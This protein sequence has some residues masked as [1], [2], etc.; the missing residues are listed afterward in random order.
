MSAV[1][2]R[3]NIHR[4]SVDLR[5]PFSDYGFDSLGATRLIADLG[6][7]LGR[8]LPATLAWEHPNI[9][10]LAQW[11]SGSFAAGERVPDGRRTEADEP[12]AVVGLACRFP[13]GRNAAEFWD[14][15]CSG[16]DA[17]S[18]VPPDRWDAAAWHDPSGSTPGKIVTRLGGFLESVDRFDSGFFGISPREAAFMDPQQRLM[19]ELSWEALEDG[20]IP[21]LSLRDS[22]TGVFFGVVW[23]DYAE[24]QAIEAV[25]P[26]QHTAAGHSASIVA[27][28]VSYV[29]GLRGPSLA[30]DTACSS[31]LVAVHQA[32]QSLRGGECN[33][34]LAGGVML[35]L[36]PRTSGAVSAF[37]GLSPDGRCK[38][39][40]ASANGYV[41]G[42]G[43][44]VVVLKRL[45]DALAGG[46]PIYCVI[47]GSA[48]NN[49]GAT[50]G[51]T[52]PSL[53]A[54][55]AVLA[56]ACAS[57]GVNP[58]EVGYVELHGT[59]TPLGDPIEARALG[60]VL[61]AGRD[62]QRPLLAGS[63][64]TNIGHLEG[65]AGIA[66][67]IKVALAMRHGAIPPS[68]HFE[69][70]NP[71]IDFDGLRLRVQTR[72]TPWP[73]W[74]ER[75]IAGVSSFG[76]GGTNSH[77]VVEAAP[78]RERIDESPAAGPASAEVAF[79]FSGAGP[80]WPG[81]GRELLATEP[82]FRNKLAECDAIL[83][84][85]AGWSLFDELLAEP[86]RIRF[87]R[88]EVHLPL[89]FSMQVALAALWESL[90]VSPGAVVGYSIGEWAAAHAAGAIGLEDGLRIAVEYAK[91]VRPVSGAAGMAIV[92]LPADEV[93]KLIAPYGGRLAISADNGGGSTGVGGERPA[94]E[95][96]VASLR[97]V[98][99]RIIDIDCY[100][101]IPHVDPL[102]PGFREAL[103]GLTPKPLARRMVSTVSGTWTRDGELGG[104][105]WVDNFREPVAF[106]PAVQTLAGAGYRRFVEVTPHPVHTY[107]LKH[108]LG[109]DSLPTIQRGAGERATIRRS[110]GRLCGSGVEPEPAA[111]VL[112][113]S[114]HS[115]EALRE[116]AEA[117][118]ARIENNAADAL[119]DICYTAARRR[120]HLDHRLAVTADSA[121]GFV[122]KL[123]GFAA[124]E[125]VAGAAHGRVRAQNTP[126]IAF[127][128]SGQGTLWTGVAQRLL[129]DEPVFREV[130]DRCELYIRRH[131]GWSL[132]GELG[133]PAESSRF[134][135][136]DIAQPLQFAIQAGLI[137]LWKHWGVTPDG[138]AGHSVGEYA[139]AYAAG[140]MDLEDAVRAVCARGRLMQQAAGRGAMASVAA[141]AAAVGGLIG[142]GHGGISISA[143][144]SPAATVVSGD[145]SALADFLQSSQQ[146]G[147]S[148]QR[149]PVNYAFH[150]P[151]MAEY[152]RSLVEQLAGIAFRPASTLF[153]STVTGLRQGEFD[154]AYW[155]RN[156]REPVRFSA[157]IEAMA[158][159]GFNVFLEISPHRVLQRAMAETLE[160]AGRKATVV[161]SLRSGANE[162]ATLREAVGTLY[163]AGVPL[164]WDRLFPDGGQVVSLV[165]YP[166]QRERAWI[167]ASGSFRK[168]PSAGAANRHPLLGARLR[169]V[170]RE[171]EFECEIDGRDPGPLGDH[172]VYGAL[173][174]PAASHV[175][176]LI[177]AAALVSGRDSFAL[178]DLAFPEALVIDPEG[179]KTVHVALNGDSCRIASL[180]GGAWTSHATARVDLDSGAPVS[181]DLAAIRSRCP[182]EMPGA[183]LYGTLRE[184]G[185]LLGPHYQ[186]VD[187][188]WR[189]GREALGRM[190]AASAEDAR[191]GALIPGGLI[192]SCFQLLGAA[193]SFEVQEGVA[194][195]PISIDAVRW[196][197]APAGPL[198][199][200]MVHRPGSGAGGT[201]TADLTLFQE[202]GTV[203]VQIEGLTVKRAPRDLFLRDRGIYRELVWER[204][205]RRG[206]ESP[207]NGE[208]LIVGDGNGAGEALA[209]ALAAQ[210]A[211][212]TTLRR[213]DEAAAA[214]RF[215]G[216]VYLQALDLHDS[217]GGFE[218]GQRRVCGDLV[219]LVQ[220]VARAGHSQP[221]RLWLVT[222]GAQ[223]T[224]PSDAPV[225]IAQAPLWGLGNALA[226]EHPE[227]QC[228]RVDLD[229]AADP[230]A[231]LIEELALPPED[232]GVA[233]RGGVR[234][235]PRLAPRAVRDGAPPPVNAEGAY[236]VTGG[237]GGLGLQAARWLVES[238]ARHVVLMGRGEPSTEAAELIR[239]L[240]SAGAAVA[241]ERGD[242][243][244]RSDVQRAV[245]NI[246]PSGRALK[247]VIHC[248]GV[249]DD[250]VL[251]EQDWPR[252][253]NAM[254]AKLDG[255]W[256]LHELTRDEALDW[257][258]LFSSAAS[259]L[260]APGQANYAAANAFLNALAHYRRSLGLTATAVQ[261]GP[262][263]E[264]GMAAR[265]GA[266]R[267]RSWRQ[268]GIEPVPVREGFQALSQVLASDLTSV[269]V[270]RSDKTAASAP[271]EKAHRPAKSDLRTQLAGATP[272]ARQDLIRRHLHKQACAI[273]GLDE[274]KPIDPE[275]PL[276]ELGFD[277]LMA[278]ELRN[279]LAS[280]LGRALPATLLFDYPTLSALAGYLLS[281]YSETAPAPAAKPALT[282]A[283]P[284]LDLPEDS[285][286]IIGMA[287]RFPGG[288]DT[289]ERYW[290]NLRNGIDAISEAPRS[291]WDLDEFYDANPDAAG[292]MYSRWGGFLSNIDQFDP[293]FFGIAPR[294]AHGMDPQQRM[295]LEVSWEAL[296]RAGLPAA[297]LA[298][299][300]TGVFLGFCL[301]DYAQ[302]HLYSSD[303]S[304]IDAYSGTGSVGS[305]AAGRLSYVFGLQGPCLAVDTACSSSLVSVH[306]AC[307]SIR[308]GECDVALAGGVNLLLSPNVTVYFSRL[309]ALSP[310]GRCKA[311]DAS[312]NGYVRGEG[313]GM[314]VLKRL[315]R[316]L[317]DGDRILAVVRGSAVNQ[318][319]RSN[320]L[321]APSGKAQ[322]QVLRRALADA[323]L[324]PA[325]IG[326]VE[327]HGTGTQLGDPIEVGAL[328][329]VLGEGRPPENRLRIGSVKTNI[330]HLEGAA[331]IAGLMKAVLVLQHRQIPPTLHLKQPNPYIPWQELPLEVAAE[332]QP[333][334]AAG[335]A[336]IAGVSSFGFS[337]TNA[338]VVLQEA[339][340]FAPAQ[341]PDAPDDRAH[342]LTLSAKSGA[343]LDALAKTTRESLAGTESTTAG[344]CYTAS[345]RRSHHEYRL[346]VAGRTNDALAEALRSYTPRHVIAGSRPK[347]AFIFSGHGS[348]WHGMGRQMLEREPAFRET[349]ERCASAIQRYAGWDL[350]EQLNGDP[351]QS[352]L[353]ESDIAQ[354]AIF[355]VQ[356]SLAALWRSWGVEPEAVAGHS[357]GEIAAAQ[358]A[359]VLDL[360]DAARIVCSRTRLVKAAAG[361]G[362]MLAVDLPPE[363][364]SAL[365][366]GGA[367]RLWIAAVNSPAAVVLSGE[368]GAVDD[369]RASLDATGVY[370]RRVDV[371]YASHCPLMDPYREQLARSLQGIA[372]R[373]PAIP[374]YSTVTGRPA[375]PEDFTPEYWS[376]HLRQPVRF[377]E[378]IDELLNGGCNIF[379]CADP[380]P[381]LAQPLSQCIES[382][383][384]A[385]EVVVSLRRNQDEDLA[386][387][388]GLGNLYT[389]GYAVDWKRQFAAPY[390]P[391]DL[392]SYP[393]QHQRYWVDAAPVKA[394][395]AAAAGHPLLGR[396]VRAAVSAEL[397]ESEPSLQSLPLLNDHRAYGAPVVAGACHLA[398]ALCGAREVTRRETFT[399]RNAAFPQALVLDEE[400]ASTVQLAFTPGSGGA[401]A[402]EVHSLSGDDWR[403]HASGTVEPGAGAVP[404]TVDLESLRR[405]AASEISSAAFY[406]ALRQQGVDYGPTFRWIGGLWQGP[407]E[408]LGSFR[409]PAGE[410]AAGEYVLHPG[411]IDSWFQLLRAVP[412]LARDTGDPVV[413]V[414]V[415]SLRVFAAPKGPLW[416]HAAWKPSPD[417]DRDTFTADLLLF[418]ESGECVAEARGLTAKRAPRDLF[419]GAVDIRDWFYEV[420][421][422]AAELRPA[423]AAAGSF[424][425]VGG[426]GGFADAVAERLQAA[427]ARLADVAQPGDS[428]V[429][430]GALDAERPVCRE[431]FDALPALPQSGKLWLVTRGAQPVGDGVDE[432]G[433]AQ[434]PLWGMGLSLAEERPELRCI[435]VDL[436]PGDGA[437]DDLV[438]ELLHGGGEERVAWRNGK[439]HA[440][441]LVRLGET[442]SNRELRLDAD[443]AYLITGG[444]GGLGLKTAE[445]MVESGA[446]HIVLA[447]R[448][449]PSTRALEA[450]GRMEA[451]G[452]RVA[453]EHADVT[454]RADVENL[455]S[456]IRPLRGVVHAAGIL[457]DGILEQ[458]PWERFHQVMA[459]KAEGAWH[460][461]E[462]TA[463]DNLD[464]FVLF[465]SAVSV[466][467]SAGQANHAAGNAYLDALAHHR[468][469]LGLPA[470]SIN[471]G[472][473]SEIGQAAEPHR[474]E[475][476]Q[477]LGIGSIAPDRGIEALGRLMRR[478]AV[479]AL[480]LPVDWKRWSEN[481][482][483][484]QSRFLSELRPALQTRHERNQG[485]EFSAASIA[486]AAPE[487]RA[488]LVREALRREAASV[489]QLQSDAL[490]GKQ[491]LLNYGLDSLMALEL[492]RRM[493]RK[494]G[495]SVPLA[496]LLSGQTLEGLEEFILQEIAGRAP[497]GAEPD[498]SAKWVEI[499]L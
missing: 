150:S 278:V 306:L 192:D 380:H 23:R 347:L 416:G 72:L 388:T 13:K 64:K 265:T 203:A 194:F 121:S 381:V 242:V 240:E 20:G 79:I 247:G 55:E 351:A 320:G 262:W 133:A 457:D 164:A 233:W 62:P 486:Q 389:L 267:M 303:P 439:R 180:A 84:R 375:G 178:R 302:L 144:N 157:A 272:Q 402:F 38:T 175:A 173:V 259:I 478:D 49:D 105:Y 159:D 33:A 154:A 488:S 120:S 25:D 15:L 493:D 471:W 484:T 391:A 139:A 129:R 14:T 2:N 292:K 335:G 170:D 26:T 409:I 365:L 294:E 255:A 60:A 245:D 43:A 373:P 89:M 116:M 160:S 223:S 63:V 338:H 275:R 32:C 385:A 256:N 395:P 30:V 132:Y 460:L 100:A 291:R 177:T 167:P 489:L 461:H 68:L 124:G 171:A 98:F 382:R 393:W 90:G 137:A 80:A 466:I 444:F 329:A 42:E 281:E 10:A 219:R 473:W 423:A 53:A 451:A 28:R 191:D 58:A 319:G 422:Q 244:S 249:L 117:M 266:E 379:L 289:P 222:R 264:T 226:E 169:A 36:S 182:R 97:G 284:A 66:G 356:V 200:H 109:S 197:G 372:V 123:R 86:E 130:L 415:D 107:D 490:E 113:L 196:F 41:R 147:Y 172:E 458:I 434:A 126:K 37:G 332:L 307:Q 9:E 210:G 485:E 87:N 216:I 405:Q 445:W 349:M 118:A 454:K 443:G 437:V 179:S 74:A 213:F 330:G 44:G 91:A 495:V 199:C 82:V 417:G 152:Q 312:A 46:D 453:V 418:E 217:G 56:E 221:P 440:A 65:A 149:L 176:R 39:F 35:L 448:S 5:R 96:F 368:A 340:A 383:G 195:V 181:L 352:R 214:G 293:G 419:L 360:D 45:S 346:A 92:G 491:A 3:L 392:P 188:L 412:V 229:P 40:D 492:R 101:H 401:R 162:R 183:D 462:L 209:S 204:A 446:R 166:W 464:F 362:A 353:S 413:P 31:S 127:V 305:V 465:S 387:K 414:A 206:G 342:V 235:V 326:Y 438:T 189:G 6:R 257:F 248:A 145:S 76:F 447:G 271:R 140:V 21:P 431:F 363:Q 81:M 322:E 151:Q 285:I 241:I 190:R 482:P 378:A 110:L 231:A 8:E 476:L 321:T 52:A 198:W 369:F 111:E 61:C 1:S 252:F 187:A 22:R 468:R 348:Q 427:G 384:K 449:Q 277:S 88:A 207:L 399:I 75:R 148:A 333:W 131:G 238:G 108:V 184:Q 313:C 396:R 70:P 411:L 400:R 202:D 269:A 220:A 376:R 73:E 4:E 425:L 475:R 250:G 161:A 366:N 296:E 436:G 69:Q 450:I 304:R 283:L 218:A 487:V 282:A 341:P 361:R 136:T 261:W 336:R 463:G 57:A 258:V 260:R 420:S 102:T 403:L 155:G 355:S 316:A 104:D 287:C 274:E 470:L 141:A 398:L 227:F 345:V 185:L 83:Q 212:C 350:F 230:V 93:R 371:D 51:L 142:A 19:L 499:E 125:N 498:S 27:N 103:S 297:Q 94:L 115:P 386:L 165:P 483:D 421:W 300:E 404:A 325:D 163:A 134:D 472:P 480:V 71:H 426:S 279:Q 201:A 479:Q 12:V 234:L 153:F 270:F 268:R 77:V 59:G 85:L 310:D 48:V 211:R 410:Q 354:P 253:W 99:C 280:S 496:K 193:E 334:T 442:T 331:G 290:E 469:G 254:G 246:R 477:K 494:L 34:A 377:R 24:L 343:A 54:Q 481:A 299:T 119:G 95:Q 467:G 225:E 301:S 318:D 122:H 374:I 276:R 286:A 205:E 455:L 78:A 251:L 298:G 158:A 314:I 146:A 317:A 11:L 315:S 18:E 174:V 29:F 456:R 7:E 228:V 370:C 309:T 224:S 135:R 106:V 397:F 364:V 232:D 156:L 424:L 208:W 168:G 16:V 138:V 339:P 408:A 430:L 390:P 328:G 428:I 435:H 186:W 215:D 112:A 432:A 17:I 143:V 273:L 237:L 239:S 308:K 324:N 50:N 357:S 295:L 394:R 243:R 406:E 433:V 429:Y 67:L 337:G 497:A 407:G 344:V 327:A 459:V 323:R 128:F 359:G 263:A 474:G 367:R 441:R 452:A 358:V 47:R 236:L 311:F 288:A 114:A